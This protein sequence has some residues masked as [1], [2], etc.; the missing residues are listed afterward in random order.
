MIIPIPKPYKNH[1]NA[2]NYRPISLL[3]SLSKILEKLILKRLNS[4][5][6]KTQIIPLHQFGFIK[7]VSTAHQLLRLSEYIHTAYQNK[8]HTVVS[9]LDISQAFDR[10]WHEGLL[11]KLRTM[12]TPTYL[13]KVIKSFLTD[14]SFTVSVENH[15]SNPRKILAGLPQ[16][17]PLS[18]TLF[19][20]YTA[21]IPTTIHTQL[22]QFADDTAI[23]KSSH[24]LKIITDRIQHH[25]NK[26]DNWSTL[27]KIKLN[28]SKSTAKIFSLRP[29]AHPPPL[30]INKHTIPW[31]SQN[32]T[33]KYLGLNFDTRLNWKTHIT[34]KQQQAK[35]KIAQ[36]KPLINFKSCLSL[37]NAITL[38]KAIVRPLMLYACPIWT[39]ASIS[40][41]NKLQVVQNRFLRLA[42]KA[43][44]FISNAQL[45]KELN[46]SP[47]IKH[48]AHL[49]NNF[50]SNLNTINQA[51]HYNLASL[52]DLP[53]RIKNRFP[54]EAFL[55][56]F[57]LNCSK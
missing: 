26:I 11:Y 7:H 10:V 35:I 19:N 24:S 16:G 49:S 55:Q 36:L 29:F 5:L 21:D 38:Y 17:S 28:P 47:I 50:Y 33:V 4:Y 12:G 42:T 22:A 15:I 2:E 54:F 20:I 51:V 14:R 41:I 32:Q 57:S 56:I 13:V 31:T 3:T 39:N 53:T 40:N 18:P 25:L 37:T 48:I 1:S 43:P 46:I 45:H 8:H 23:Y 52:N 30:H 9:F 6:Q 44:W 27:W 34:L